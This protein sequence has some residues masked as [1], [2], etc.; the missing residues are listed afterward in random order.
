MAGAGGAP[1][2]GA[3]AADAGAAASAGAAAGAGAAGAGA[4][5]AGAV[6]GGALG[7]GAFGAESTLSS[8]SSS[9]SLSSS[10]SMSLLLPSLGP[11]LFFQSLGSWKKKL[12][13][14]T[15]AKFKPT[16]VPESDQ[17]G[18]QKLAKTEQKKRIKVM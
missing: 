12:Q 4:G 5:A 6:R 14:A 10:S 9:L 3:G 17:N 16:W 2:S 11:G 8:S 1:D 7:G 18:P 13:Q 15:W